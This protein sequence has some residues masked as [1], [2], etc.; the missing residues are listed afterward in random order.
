M[1]TVVYMILILVGKDNLIQRDNLIAKQGLQVIHGTSGLNEPQNVLCC[2]LVLHRHG[3]HQ[4]ISSSHAVE[5]REG[6]HHFSCLACIV[7]A[8]CTELG[9][10]VEPCN[11][12]KDEEGHWLVCGGTHISMVGKLSLMLEDTIEVFGVITMTQERRAS[13]KQQDNVVSVI[14]MVVEASGGCHG[15]K[16]GALKGKEEGRNSD[17]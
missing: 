9:S 11:L 13:S 17:G 3:V 7:I 5:S 16:V 14:H 12:P 10:P 2:G 1:H 15:Q 4:R 6:T 8:L